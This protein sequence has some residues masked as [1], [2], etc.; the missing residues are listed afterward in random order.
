MENVVPVME[1]TPRRLDERAFGGAPLIYESLIY[2]IEYPNVGIY[3]PP[4]LR[5]MEYTK[6]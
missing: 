1:V 3:E 2:E 6:L 5:T 4:N